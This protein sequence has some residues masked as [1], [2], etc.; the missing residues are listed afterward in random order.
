M[1]YLQN[2]QSG[3]GS[4]I[5]RI[6]NDAVSGLKR[7]GLV[8]GALIDAVTNVQM[9]KQRYQLEKIDVVLKGD[10]VILSLYG[11][12]ILANGN[13]SKSLS[14]IPYYQGIEVVK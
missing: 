8:A 13:F 3:I 7:Q 2:T 12:R 11:Y 6:I 10:R 9:H 4:E 1:I 14:F 5:T